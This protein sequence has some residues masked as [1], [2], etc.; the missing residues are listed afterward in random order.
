M[1]QEKHDDDREED[2]S[3]KGGE[4]DGGHCDGNDKSGGGSGSGSG[5]TSG[6]GGS[7]GTAGGSTPSNQGSVTFEYESAGYKNAIGMY[8]I[9]ADGSIKDV[10]IV[11]A[12]ASLDGSGGSLTGGKSSAGVTVNPEDKVGF[13][14]IPNGY[15]QKGMAD[16][17]ND[18]S[19]SFKFVGADGK[20]GNVNGGTELKLV[21][22][23][24]RGNTVDMKGQYGTTTF[25]SADDG[26]KGLNGDNLNHVKVSASADGSVRIG[27]EDLKNGGDKDYDNSVI[28]FRT[29]PA[30]KAAAEKAA[31][32]KA[33]AEKAAA[34]KAAAEKAAA[35]K[36]AAEKAA[37]EKAAYDAAHKEDIV[38]KTAD[39]KDVV[40]G[41]EQHGAKHGDTLSGGKG[42]DTLF[43]HGGNDTIDGD[44]NAGV[45]VALDIATSLINAKDADAIELVLS[46]L[47]SDAVL[48]AGV[49]NDDGSW[50]L[51][52]KELA[53][54]TVTTPDSADFDV[55]V[56][57]QATDGSGLA[58]KSMIHV[59]MLTGSDDMISGGKGN[60]T[61][62]GDQGDDVMYGAGKWDGIDRPH[63]PTYADNDVIFGGTGNDRIWGNAGDDKLFGD[64]GNDTVFGGKG[65]DVITGGDSDNTLYG[66]SGDDVFVAGGGND[67][68]VGG[69]GFDTIDFSNAKSGVT[70][71]LHK[72]V[73]Y[74]DGKGSVSGVEAV[75]GS[76][77]D[78]VIWGDKRA[79]VFTGGE[80]NDTFGFHSGNFRKGGA[81]DHVTDFGKGD[82]L[83]L[84]EMLH[85]RTDANSFRVTEGKD[86]LHISVKIGGNFQ[87]VVTLDG[88][89][90][91]TA[92]DM[93]HNGMILA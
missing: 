18:T 27:F 92:Q 72:H 93:L 19:G 59:T 50:T 67:T 38:L 43:G 70:I 8:K 89:H 14:I 75:V 2:K 41:A 44:K 88:V 79:N 6:A 63:E 32:E 49:R 47:P 51:S 7:T 17:L 5:S 74:G 30:E 25:H 46:G 16:L 42:N 64:E 54:L 81:V 20:P 80:G 76:A 34:E 53:G 3:S 28:T 26:S 39:A 4:H 22:V 82:R 60:D 23:D 78:D 56:Y 13:F 40:T 85:G 36:A 24:A 52:V 33:A 48:S 91:M 83:D 62:S 55:S 84:S 10:E 90:G 73:A 31:A 58:A 71:D 66:N 69:S 1:H 61:L 21:H 86:G 77:Y 35:E 9:G 11:F 45:T 29:S 87:D 12:N 65:N 57:A 15:S 68:I 37:A